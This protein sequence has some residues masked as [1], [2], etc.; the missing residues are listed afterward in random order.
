MTPFAAASRDGAYRGGM[1]GYDDKQQNYFQWTRHE[2][3][4]FVPEG[5][6]SV[7]EI[8]CGTGSFGAA[9]KQLRGCRY[10]GLEL[11]ENAA[12]EA[13]TRLDEAHALDIEAAPL[14][15]APATFDCLVCND[16]LE[17][18]VDPWAVLRK[19]RVVLQ[20]GAY[21]VA[22]LPNLRYFEVMKDL[23]LRGRFDY[24]DSGVL[25]RT[26]LRFFTRHSARQ[27]IESSGAQVLR[28]EGINAARLPWKLRLFNSLVGGAL[29]DTR[30]LQY[31]CLARLPA[32]A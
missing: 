28:F 19:L 21:V 11:F 1:Q 17:H 15:F 5:V 7:L 29:D 2:M 25:D 8:G 12:A 22:S 24:Q 3:L 16:V 18:L 31:A 27:L 9:I 10:T 30:F 14:P 4:P 26:H 6:R 23:V 13:R 32:A 20:P